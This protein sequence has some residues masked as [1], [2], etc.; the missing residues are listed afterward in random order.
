MRLRDQPLAVFAA[1]VIAVSLLLPIGSPS[2]ALASTTTATVGGTLTG[3]DGAPFGGSADD[4]LMISGYGLAVRAV[5]VAGGSYISSAVKADGSFSISSIPAGDYRVLFDV[6]TGLGPWLDTYYGSTPSSGLATVLTLAPGDS[7]QLEE[8]LLQEGSFTIAVRGPEGEILPSLDHHTFTFTPLGGAQ[9]TGAAAPVRHYNR[10]TG[11]VSYSRLWPGEYRIGSLPP[12][13]YEVVFWPGVGTLDEA[14]P[15]IVGSGDHLSDLELVVPRKP[16]VAGTVMITGLDEPIPA[17]NATVLLKSGGTVARSAS[18]DEQGRFELTGIAYGEYTL[19]IQESHTDLASQGFYRSCHGESTE[20]PSGS[21]VTVQWGTPVESL[22]VEVVAGARI[23]GNLRVSLPPFDGST[24]VTEGSVVY[25]KKDPESERWEVAHSAGYRLAGNFRSLILE[26]GEYRVEFRPRLRV[27]G[28]WV[29]PRGFWRDARYFA[30][31]TSVHVGEAQTVVLP[32]MTLEGGLLDV[33]RVAGDNRYSTS[34]AIADA[35]GLSSPVPVV[36]IV[37]GTGY[38]DALSAGPA[39]TA[40]GGLMLLVEQNSVPAAVADALEGLRPERIVVVGGTSVISSKVERALRE[41]TD[42]PSDVERI[43]GVNRYET[44]RLLVLDAF[45]DDAPLPALFLAT[46]RNFPDALA[47]GPAASRLGGAVMLVDG[48][49]SAVDSPTRSALSALNPETIYL[50]GMT[51]SISSGIEAKLRSLPQAFSVGRLG[52]ADRYATSRQIAS[53]FGADYSWAFLA[54]GAGFADALAGG[55]L[56]ASYD[57]PLLLSQPRCI[58]GET[59]DGFLSSGTNAL[60]LVGGRSVLTRDVE[61]IT[62][63]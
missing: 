6:F 25:W 27:D 4:I 45:G 60:V 56:A 22:D 30:D 28:Q 34:V 3:L 2:S 17:A 36:Y 51:G 40:G 46:G 49:A 41:F 10:T 39:A 20:N 48:A 9:S 35:M 62:M 1:A 50:T 32:P 31:A 61:R 52:G 57:A 58:P 11:V 21:V 42:A 38:A 43:A 44:S 53:V 33:Y 37:N 12:P 63:C 47:A 15:I 5:P 19:C 18:A 7:V 16:R 23:V 8:S 13:D 24:L 54:T 29:R 14:S 55:P 59:I 26:P